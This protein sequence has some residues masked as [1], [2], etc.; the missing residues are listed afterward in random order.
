MNMKLSYRDKIIFI[1][2]IIIVIL[3][4]GFF[5][6]I[7]PKFQEID[8]ARANYEAKKQEQADID[9]KIS[10]LPQLIEDIKSVAKD[11]GEK[12]ELFMAEQDPYL[13]EMYV[14]EALESTGIEYKSI[15][16]TY[17]SAGPISRYTV[18]P[19]HLLAYDNKISADLYHELPEELY[20]NYLGV[21]PTAYPEETIGVTTMEL[22]FYG[23]KELDDV[24]NVIN[25]LSQDDKA[26][27]LNSVSSGDVTAESETDNGQTEFSCVIT[28][29]SVYPLNVDKVM[30]EDGDWQ[31][32][33]GQTPASDE[34]A[35]Q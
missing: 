25:K 1:V 10:T 12:Q 18:T 24:Y 4:A 28:I 27:I 33:I 16:T 34:A 2:V 15:S 32:Y 14:R 20:N 8:S 9:A 35:A 29:Y 11:V 26:V 13:N 23:D 30:E 7:R 21:E 19:E 5:L 22:N 17:T 31:Q 3:V 6:L